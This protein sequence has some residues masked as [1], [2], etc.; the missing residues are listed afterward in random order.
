M[1]NE[2]NIGHIVQENQV[3]SLSPTYKISTVSWVII[4]QGKQRNAKALIKIKEIIKN[5]EFLN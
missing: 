1:K 3:T 5:Q 2:E 4:Y